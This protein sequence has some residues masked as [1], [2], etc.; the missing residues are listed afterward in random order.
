MLKLSVIST[1]FC[2]VATLLIYKLS[3]TWGYDCDFCQYQISHAYVL[4]FIS[5]SPTCFTST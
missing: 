2:I 5:L 4:S 3:H 1:K